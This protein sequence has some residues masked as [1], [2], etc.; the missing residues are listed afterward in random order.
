MLGG[1]YITL[2]PRTISHYIEYVYII[3]SI[4]SRIPFA[5]ACLSI[6]SMI[7]QTYSGTVW[8]ALL[9][10]FLQFIWHIIW[11]F[12][13][14]AYAESTAEESDDTDLDTDTDT[15]ED[16]EGSGSTI[17]WFLL[18]ISYYWGSNVWRNVSHTTTC[19]VTATWYFNKNVLP[20]PSKAAFKRTMSTSFGSVAFGSLIVAIIQALKALARS[21]GRSGGCLYCVIRCLEWMARYFNKY[22]FAQVAIYGSSYIESAK[23]TWELF[24]SGSGIIK[25]LI[26]DDLTGM[27]L[28]CG[29]VLG[30]V[31]AGVIGYFVA[32]AFYQDTI[33][34]PLLPIIAAIVG[35]L[36]GYFAVVII[37]L[38]VAS[39][40]VA[41]F[42]CFAEDPAACAENRPEAYQKLTG[43]DPRLEQFVQERNG[44]FVSQP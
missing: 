28:S 30:L 2:Y 31:V 19:G 11:I 23:A 1:M 32:F 22:A 25:A 24:T 17:V 39:G 44:E 42:V 38:V 20:N 27:A 12:A 37:L 21:Q 43:A 10:V 29:A 40:V 18:F 14:V 41:I 33:F 35:A 26:N 8:I 4:W 36:L 6:A 9:T 3:F 13:A 5:G 7:A 16:S 34:D 15:D